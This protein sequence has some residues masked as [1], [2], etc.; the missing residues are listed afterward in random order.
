MHFHFTTVEV[1]WTL[2]FAALLVLLVILLGRDRVRRFPW[3]TASIVLLALRMLASRLLFGKLAPIPTNEIFLTL[4]DAGTI[5]AFLVAVEMARRAFARASRNL[6]IAGTLLLLAIAAMVVAL[7]GP[8]PA[9]KTV[10]ANTTLG[11]LRLMQLVAQKGELLNDLLYIELAVL[12]VFVARRFQAGWR[13][14]ARQIVS[15]LAIASIAQLVVRAVW[16]K[17]A[18]GPPPRTQEEYLRIT[19]LQEKLFNG[20]S[21]VYLV[22]LVVWIICLWR[23]EPGGTA[24]DA[25]PA[26]IAGSAPSG[27]AARS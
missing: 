20:N 8:W 17:I 18:N 22:V 9:W 7:W 27:T 23:D 14:H 19:G 12:L 11:T 5:V 2:T 24:A 25:Q 4:A 6:W 1:L 3:F 21:V 13:N 16:Q 15:G 10:E 26:E